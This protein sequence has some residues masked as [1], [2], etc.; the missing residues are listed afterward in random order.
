MTSVLRFLGL[1]AGLMLV[2]VLALLAFRLPVGPSLNLLLEG[3]FGDKFAWGR[4]IVKTIPLLL[5]G[6]GMVVAWRAGM[7]NIGGEGQFIVG[8]IGG[9]IIGR[10]LM[11]S[12]LANGFGTVLVLLACIAGGA[13]WA[14]IAAWL[15]LRRGVEIVI[16]TILLNF[17][18]IQVL[19]WV[20]SGPLQERSR[21]VP[22]TDLLP[23]A[24]MLWRPDRQMDVN[25]GGFLAL[26]AAFGIWAFLFR[27]RAGYRLRLVGEN[28]NVARV[29]YIDP[30]RVQMRA[31]AISG[32]LCGLAGGI[33]Y[34]GIAGQLQTTFS[35]NWGFLGIPVALLANL[36]PLGAIPAAAYFGALFAGSEN[37]GRFTQGG[38][39]L[40]YVIQAAAVLAFVWVGTVR[41][42]RRK[43]AVEA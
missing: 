27:T 13:F 40:V 9:A 25:L 15:Y 6:L 39:T 33:E 17:V 2:L 19:G 28:G 36:H 23:K 5:T 14:W 3:A 31:M 30:S 20:C 7:Y 12:P 26:L 22:Q 35:Q 38:P 29:N 37:L 43:V 10:M 16:G 34:L 1:A 32:G 21:A 42:R 24:M 4:T 11:E 41:S 18:A 8:G